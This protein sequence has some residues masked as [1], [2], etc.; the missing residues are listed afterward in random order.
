MVSRPSVASQAGVPVA[1]DDKDK[2][3][4]LGY[5]VD[6]IRSASCAPSVTV[7]SQFARVAAAVGVWL[8]HCCTST[9]CASLTM[10]PPTT[11]TLASSGP[12]I[13]G[14][15]VVMWVLQV[16]HSLVEKPGSGRRH[17]GAVLSRKQ[18]TYD[19]EL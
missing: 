13:R 6:A 10:K 4:S 5:D 19:V 11:A 14:V 15:D 18:L 16:I 7:S 1:G 2:R 8:R 9:D 12:V 3:C 17:G